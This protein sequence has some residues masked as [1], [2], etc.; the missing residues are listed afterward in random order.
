LGGHWRQARD[1]NRLVDLLFLET[2]DI[3]FLYLA[4][5]HS[6]NLIGKES[7]II[8]VRGGNELGRPV[9]QQMLIAVEEYFPESGILEEEGVMVDI[10][11]DRIFGS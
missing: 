4:I 1:C 9:Y 7:N 10:P 11:S 8:I 3:D 5:G 2:L 6:T